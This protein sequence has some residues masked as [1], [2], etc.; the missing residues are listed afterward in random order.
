MSRRDCPVR[1]PIMISS[2][3]A[4]I[5]ALYDRVVF[6]ATCMWD[7]PLQTE[8]A[9]IDVLKY[10]LQEMIPELAKLN[11]VDLPP[12]GDGSGRAVRLGRCN[13]TVL[14]PRAAGAGGMGADCVSAEALCAYYRRVHARAGARRHYYSSYVQ[15][16]LERDVAAFDGVRNLRAF[17][18]YWRSFSKRLVKRP[19]MC[20]L[21]SGLHAWLT[22]WQQAETAF[23]GPLAG[24]LLESWVV[25][26]LIRSA[27]H[28]GREHRLSFWRTSTGGELDVWHEN[29]GRIDPAPLQWGR[30]LIITF[31]DRVLPLAE[32]TWQV[33]AQYP[34]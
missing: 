21:D 8:A 26:L 5:R 17:E 15:T 4:W 10:K 25:A 11:G 29:E 24:A 27:W 13:S 1:T 20:F 18:P 28:R 16:Y 9:T 30:R 7:A 33:P 23:A 12:S 22:G 3:S 2:R 6:A 34:S 14:Q 19:R 32:D 31:G